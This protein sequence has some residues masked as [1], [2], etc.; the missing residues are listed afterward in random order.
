MQIKNKIKKDK[1]KHGRKKDGTENNQA[2]KVII[3]KQVKKESYRGKGN[4][5]GDNDIFIG[6]EDSWTVINIIFFRKKWNK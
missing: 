5:I 2:W 4:K 6:L 1:F 3:T